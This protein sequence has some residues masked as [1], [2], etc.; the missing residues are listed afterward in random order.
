MVK[1][2]LGF[3]DYTDLLLLPAAGPINNMSLKCCYLPLASTPLTTNVGATA[4]V[5]LSSRRDLFVADKGF[6]GGL[7]LGS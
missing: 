7:D 3:F 5:D 4:L 2:W 6:G 1:S